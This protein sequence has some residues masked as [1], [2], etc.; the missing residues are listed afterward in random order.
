VALREKWSRAHQPRIVANYL[1]ASLAATT[2]LVVWPEA[3]VPWFLDELPPEI[4]D[5]LRGARADIVFGVLERQGS[6]TAPRI[7]N[8]VVAINDSGLGLYRKRHLVPFGEFLPLKPMLGW[9][10]DVLH[11]P[12]SDFDR[13]G[14]EPQPL[15]AAGVELGVSVCYEDAFPADVRASLPRAQVLLNVSEDAWFGDSL[16]PHQ[17]LQMARLRAREAGRDLLRAANTGPSAV[18]NHR[19]AVTARTPQ[20]TPVVLPAEFQPRTGTTPY[21]RFGEWPVLLLC[22]GLLVLCAVVGKRETD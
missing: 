7:Y 11:I 19:G 12:M 9:L 22:A 16:A 13:W 8:S 17:R 15:Q 18:I 6:G 21:V 14:A 3:A 5:R 10:L 2:D 1:A 20:F 4:L